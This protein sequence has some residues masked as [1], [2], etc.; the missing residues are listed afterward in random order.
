MPG[1]FDQNLSTTKAKR[2]SAECVRLTGAD[3]EVTVGADAG[4]SL[5]IAAAAMV[6]GTG[7]G[8]DLLLKDELVSR[9][10]LELRA[11]PDGVRAIDLGSLNGTRY[12]GA[13]IVEVLLDADATLELGGTTLAI[14]LAS[15][16]LD[17]NLSPHSQFGDAIAHSN[18]MRHVFAL[19]ERAAAGQVTVLLEGDSGTGKDVLA[20]GIHQQSSR[21]DSPFVVVDCGAIPDNLIESELFGH[22]KG[23]F[24][25]AAS[26]RPGAFE[27]ADGGTLFLDEIGELPISAQ[28]K[29]LRVLENRSFRRVGGSKTIEV[30]VRVIAA[31]N[32]RLREAVRINEFREDLFYRIAVVHVHVPRLSERPEDIV[33]LAEL[34]LRRA[35]G[36]A[37][38]RLP[39]DL[40]RL[41]ESYPWQGNARELR[42]VV[43]RFA[44]FE[45]TDAGTL[46]GSDRAD[47]SKGTGLFVGMEDMPYHDAKRRVMEAFHQAVLPRAV[48]KAGSVPRAAKALG[49]PKASLYRML[50]PLKGDDASD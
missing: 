48:D 36:D 30:D 25:G 34:F 28:P 21:S 23:A 13:R 10:H 45:R 46:F 19:L 5:P 3:V 11:E 12:R 26:S 31:T 22:E 15:E 4:L 16:P 1:G 27:Q 7:T 14:R 9:R 18:A 50:Q 17:L 6:I 39:A 2:D 40:A 32:R 49:L 20:H 38:A 33:P 44:T 37:Q 29:L 42:N 35:T 8:C 24:T 41:L 47:I 43:E